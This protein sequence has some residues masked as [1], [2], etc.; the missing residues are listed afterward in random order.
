MKKELLRWYEKFE[1]G[2]PQI[3]AEHRS[4]MEKINAFWLLLEEHADLPRLLGALHDIAGYAEFHFASEEGLMARHAYPSLDHHGEIHR[5]LLA[6]LSRRIGELQQ[7]RDYAIEAIK[8]Y[9]F[10]VDWFVRHT[11]IEDRKLGEFLV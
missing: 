6:Q 9:S 7:A 8:L 2:H 4:M 5:N 1:L 10:L 3:D 11:T